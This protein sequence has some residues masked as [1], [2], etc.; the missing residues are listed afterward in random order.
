MNA[1]IFQHTSA[2][3][4]SI[5]WY[6]KMKYDFDEAA[7]KKF[8]SNKEKDYNA[9]ISHERYA[10]AYMTMVERSAKIGSDERT[11]IKYHVHIHLIHDS[12]IFS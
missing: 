2:L 10:E 11:L 7:F 6:G 1:K 4:K 5:A 9:L 8:Q 3:I 12:D